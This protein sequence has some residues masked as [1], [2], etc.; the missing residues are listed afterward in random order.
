M[1]GG[2]EVQLHPFLPSTPAGAEWLASRLGRFILGKVPQ[3]LLGTPQSR[4]RQL[5][6]CSNSLRT[7]RSEGSNLGEGKVFLTVQTDHGAHVAFY[8]KGYRVS[9]RVLKRLGRG[10]HQPPPC[11]PQVKER[12]ELYL[13]SPSG[14]SWPVSG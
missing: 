14:P 3:Q 5:S 4:S 7:G 9:F 1:Y 11:C 2:V 13:Y 12:V 6:R 10:V 8:T